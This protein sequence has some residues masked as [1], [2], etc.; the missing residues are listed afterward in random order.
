V[1]LVQRF[2]R[3]HVAATAFCCLLA[4]LGSASGADVPYLSGR[5]VDD[6]DVLNSGTRARLSAVLKAHEQS[7]GNQIAVL[8]VP[9]IGDDSIEAYA[10]KV[11][12]TWKLGQKG[13]DNGVLLVIAPKDRKLRIEVGYGLE[14]TLTDAAASRII[15]NVI[16]PQ[17]KAGDFDKG[18]SD[19]VDA[20]IGALQ[21]KPVAETAAATPD[22]S[23]DFIHFSGPPLAWPERILLGAFI[24]GILGLFT[25][26]GVMTP[27]MGWFLY[28]FLIPFWAMFP[29]M[30]IGTRGALG[31]LGTYIVGYPIAKWIVGRSAW[32]EK[33]AQ[34]LKTKGTASV[35]GFTFASGGSSGF[36][37]G[38]G[39]GFSGGGGSSGGGGASGSW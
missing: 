25:V 32:Y 9:T 23:G 8:T 30:I 4:S 2:L 6:A 11:F 18:V 14:G 12:E 31:L 22:S 38:G 35:G 16:T 1:G 20:I 13:K 33:A 29:I 5:V 34:D 36:S 26:V 15:R 24:F 28:A 10:T 37:S 39:G 21:G 19:G 27:G 7:T 3:S 17:F